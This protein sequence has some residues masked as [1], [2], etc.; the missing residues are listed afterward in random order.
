MLE[1]KYIGFACE[2]LII[3]MPVVIICK[4]QHFGHSRISKWVFIL[5]LMSI[6]HSVL[7]EDRRTWLLSEN[8]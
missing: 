2:Y 7:L 3:I 6:T 4:S 8:F 5:F 1:G